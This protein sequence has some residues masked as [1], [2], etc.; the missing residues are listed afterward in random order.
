MKTV[1]AEEVKRDYYNA[2]SSNKEERAVISSRS[3]WQI[4]HQNK[5]R[6]PMGT[7]PIRRSTVHDV[8]RA[9]SLYHFGKK[10]SKMG[11]ARRTD[12]PDVVS[13]NGHEVCVF[14]ITSPLSSIMSIFLTFLF[15]T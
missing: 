15:Y 13:G 7:V 10:Q 5:T 6:C 1:K 3:A 4:W 14:F 2:T 11:L 12:A 8:L 9:K